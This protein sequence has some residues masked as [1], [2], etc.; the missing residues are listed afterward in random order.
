[1]KQILLSLSI[2][3][4]LAV[5]PVSATEVLL[6]GTQ[7]QDRQDQDRA[8]KAT[9]AAGL[10]PYS[11]IRKIAE[12]KVGGKIISQ[13]LVRTNTDNWIYQLRIRKK[14]GRVAFAVVNAKSGKIVS[15]K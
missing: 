6:G 8:Y 4:L 5:S 1:M 11:R 3:L 15:V 13:K 12:N 9:K 14:D 10:L 7:G 2:T